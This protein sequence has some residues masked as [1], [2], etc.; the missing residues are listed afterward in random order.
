MGTIEP[1]K[2]LGRLLAAFERVHREGLSDAL[3][4]VG[5][6][7]WLTDDFFATLEQS[8]VREHV[9]FPG[10]VPD[11]AL[12]AVYTGAQVL[13]L[14]SLSEG[15]GLPVLEAMACRTPVI[16]SDTSSLPEVA[17]DAALLVD[18]TDVDALSSALTRVLTD[19]ALQEQMRARGEAQ[20]ARFS[21][22]RTA[23]E[24]L[25]VY[26]QLADL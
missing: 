4:I 6:R 18:P 15:F 21:W 8:P 3:V 14:P 23:E 5:K 24:T 13:V 11:A 17:G 2:N 25:A 26:Q 19:S 16:C 10:F 1:R 12:P 22:E 9:I 20:A 7:G